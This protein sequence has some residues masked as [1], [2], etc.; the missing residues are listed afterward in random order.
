EVRTRPGPA[1]VVVLRNET[2][3]G[4]AAGCNQGLAA[5]CGD[6][7]VLLN[8]DTEVTAGW[9]D[10]LVAWALSDWPHV[11]LV[12]PV[13]SYAAPPQE[14]RVESRTPQELAAFAARRR[15]EH[16]GK[17]LV[18]ERLVG[19]CLLVRR[20]V[21]ERL[22]GGLDEQF[23]LGFFEDDDLCVRARAAGFRLLVALDV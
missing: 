12:G 10:G 17:A 11:G 4:F 2:N 18:V 5:A 20:D 14:G 1:R 6:Y 19:F 8:N 23:A 16:A 22:G 21:L 7:L 3:R 13:T 15:A 9:L